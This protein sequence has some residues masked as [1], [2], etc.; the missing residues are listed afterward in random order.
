MPA[1]FLP[2]RAAA[3]PA[4]DRG[5]R[6]LPNP[7]GSS[8]PPG[9]SE[10]RSKEVAKRFFPGKAVQYEE[11]TFTSN[12]GRPTRVGFRGF[13]E[14]K[15]QSNKLGTCLVC[16]VGRFRQANR[17]IDAWPTGFGIGEHCS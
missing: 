15:L 6:R 4:A 3:R 17:I 13:R 2:F 8:P 12:H 11:I 14:F 9:R 5:H 10:R 1:N 7:D 16:R